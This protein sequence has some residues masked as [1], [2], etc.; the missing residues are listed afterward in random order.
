MVMLTAMIINTKRWLFLSS[1][2]A[3]LALAALLAWPHLAGPQGTHAIEGRL[4]LSPGADMSDW[5]V[6]ATNRIFA[7]L[8]RDKDG[9]PLGITPDADGTFALPVPDGATI[10]VCPYLGTR[11]APDALVS[12]RSQPAEE[13]PAELTLTPK[14]PRERVAFALRDSDGEPLGHVVKAHLYN[15]YGEINAAG[16]G[17]RSDLAGVIACERLPCTR[18]DLWVESFATDP[19]RPTAPPA[20][21]LFRGLE[22]TPG[23]GPVTVDLT[24]PESGAV[25]GALL[26]ADG[27]TPARE[28]VVAVQSATVPDEDTGAEAWAAAYARG[29]LAC[30]AEAKVDSDG[31][32]VLENLAPGTHALDV[33]RPGE[34]E[35]WATIDGVEVKA[36]T[37]TDL[38][39]V[40]VPSSGWQRM[41]DRRT[42][43]GW[44]ESDFYGQKEVRIENERIVLCEG[45]DMT[46]IT[47][48]KAIP[49]IEYEISLQAMRVDGSDFFCGLTFPVKEDYCSL[50]LGGWGGSVVGLSSLDGFDASENETSDWIQF[51]NQRWYRVRLRVTA[52][53]IRAW[54]DADKIIDVD[55]QDRDISTRIEVERSKPFGI[56]TWC[57]T[58]AVRDIRIRPLDD[59]AE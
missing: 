30:Y 4:V 26:T 41:F 11:L 42:L 6:L 27:E 9:S 3:G 16:G 15:T 43:E 58:G 29:A 24:L 8:P 33:R 20:A 38:G 17:V 14:P 31:R 37:V 19:G 49:R 47:W 39:K 59:G 36:G 51:D 7:E 48:T 23:D 46:G 44:A 54:L 10:F 22:V 50:I 13:R 52:E 21:A 18:Y 28:Y 2:A 53:N 55:I 34:R 57:T 32:F 40:Q 25:R 45:T 12:V 56:A 5:R 1:S 35:A